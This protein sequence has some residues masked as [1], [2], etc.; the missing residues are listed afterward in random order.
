MVKEDSS[1]VLAT[2]SLFLPPE[3]STMAAELRRFEASLDRQKDA[4]KRG[5]PDT[6]EFY[7]NWTTKL[8]GG[9]KLANACTR[10]YWRRKC[11][12][13]FALWR[14]EGKRI[15]SRLSELASHPT[16][17]ALLQRCFSLVL[18]RRGARKLREATLW[19]RHHAAATL[20]KAL[21]ALVFRRRFDHHRNGLLLARAQQAAGLVQRVWRGFSTGRC[22]ARRERCRVL[23]QELK[24]SGGGESLV[25]ALQRLEE[26]CRTRTS[27][28]PPHHP[29]H[30]ELEKRRGRQD[31]G[32]SNEIVLFFHY[33]SACGSERKVGNNGNTGDDDCGAAEE[34]PA[35]DFFAIDCS[36]LLAMATCP[37]RPFK[38][39]PPQR[40]LAHWT[41]ALVFWRTLRAREAKAARSAWS[42]EQSEAR[43]M[44]A[45]EREGRCAFS[46]LDHAASRR[47]AVR[48]RDF[49]V[50]ERERTEEGRRFLR[51]QEAAG[52]EPLAK[53][54]AA[55]REERERLRGEE[56]AQER[57]DA[58]AREAEAAEELV[59]AEFQRAKRQAL[60]LQVACTE[61]KQAKARRRKAEKARMA[62]G[63]SSS[64]A[65]ADL[66]WI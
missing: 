62:S 15:T 4:A 19:R 54:L 46:Q 23:C 28:L 1:R 12:P 24:L 37:L 61:E 66:S 6:P 56:K 3:L 33:G 57:R 32:N 2:P 8:P 47:A 20:Q 48:A 45:N 53:E 5:L 38:L 30:Q 27:A 64:G 43:G 50:E 42:R 29:Y 51:R 55:E 7:R 21:R 36:E 31:N 10:V 25:R 35:D 26:D 9:V 65:I 52:A 41:S 34:Q 44:A 14:L 22:P 17:A 16:Q 59:R 39:L 63:Y 11:A 40:L 13:A 58:A 49:A 60:L 18:A